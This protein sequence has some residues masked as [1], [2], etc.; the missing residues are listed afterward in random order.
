MRVA[1]YAPLP[2]PP[3][4]ADSN[5]ANTTTHKKKKKKKLNQAAK[6]KMKSEGKVVGE[7]GR[8]REREYLAEEVSLVPLPFSLRL[9]I[10]ATLLCVYLLPLLLLLLF[11]LR[12]SFESLEK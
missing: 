2:S 1:S 7:E 9:S 11:P 4:H 10:A 6:G 8:G 12:F 5:Q 3:P